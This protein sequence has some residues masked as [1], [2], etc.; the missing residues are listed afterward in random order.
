MVGMPKKIVENGAI[1]KI[2]LTNTQILW[3]RKHFEFGNET[4]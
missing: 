3:K 4:S 1:Y 2:K